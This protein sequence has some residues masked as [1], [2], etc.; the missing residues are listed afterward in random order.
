MTFINHSSRGRFDCGAEKFVASDMTY[1]LLA[2]KTAELP[3]FA[4]LKDDLLIESPV[5]F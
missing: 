3:F 5:S 4:S 2:A 1:G